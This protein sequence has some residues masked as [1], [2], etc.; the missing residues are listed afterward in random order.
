MHLFDR[1]SYLALPIFCWLPTINAADHVPN[2]YLFCIKYYGSV[3][4]ELELPD[5]LPRYNYNDSEICPQEMNLPV[6]SGATLEICPP[7]NSL[8]TPD[9][10][11]LHAELRLSDTSGQLTDPIDNLR[12]SPAFITN[13]SVSGPSEGG[14]RP[15]ILARDTAREESSGL[16][17]W[18]INGTQASLTDSPNEDDDTQSVYFGCR[19]EKS[20]YYCGGYEDLHKPPPGGCWASQTFNFNMRNVMNFTFRFADNEASV[21]IWA[22]S[23]YVLYTGQETGSETRAHITF[24]GDRQVPSVV[25]YAF[26]TN[27]ETDYETEKADAQARQGM[28]LEVGADGLPVLA[29][30][31]ES[32]EWYASGNGTFKAESQASGLDNHGSCLL[33]VFAMAMVLTWLLA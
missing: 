3:R 6:I 27:A 26:W 33:K 2:A 11:T 31:T 21:E 1:W 10:T 29:N 19:Y 22:A 32:A 30:H 8:N 23:P 18:I 25:D 20:P 16:P 15:A 24:G 5:A 14:G 12:L 17:T 9:S 28:R 7:L 4:A 13:G